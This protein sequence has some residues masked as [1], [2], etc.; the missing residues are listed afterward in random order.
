VKHLKKM[1]SD[2]Y[3]RYYY[4]PGM[5]TGF[6]NVDSYAYPTTMYTATN[7]LSDYQPAMLANSDGWRT[8]SPSSLRSLTPEFIP[9][10]SLNTNTMAAKQAIDSKSA[11]TAF[12]PKIHVKQEKLIKVEEPAA[13]MSHQVTPYL[14][15]IDEF[16]SDDSTSLDDL[17]KPGKRRRGKQVSPV[18]KKKRRL[19]ANARERRRMQ[20]LNDAFDRL[21]Q[22]LPQIGNDR[23][24]SKHETL[25][26]AQTY[27]TALCDLL[28]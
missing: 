19:A 22:Y 2:L 20:S 8:P 3:H 25:Q 24:L 5:D 26:M 18:V 6:E 14:P 21:R 4:L 15:Q 11:A 17:Q 12:Y 27:I 10:S 7:N 23:Q 13:M 16:Q 28:E 1:A 9:L